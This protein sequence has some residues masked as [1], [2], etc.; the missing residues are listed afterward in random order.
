MCGRFTLTYDD[1]NAIAEGL[2]VARE[3]LTMFRPRY[4][5]AP[6]DTHLVVRMHGEE[7]E[8]LEAKWGLVNAWAKGPKQAFKNINAR[9][10]T[11]DSSPAFRKAFEKRRC[12]VP[13]DGFFEWEGPRNRR[14][15]HWYH[16]PDGGLILF[17][18]LYEWRKV[19]DAW[20]ATFAIVTTGANRLIAPVHDRMP[21]ILEDEAVDEW[22]LPNHPRPAELKRLLSPAPEALLVSRRVSIR[23]NDVRNDD[24]SVLEEVTQAGLV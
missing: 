7:R 5:I 21:V 1:V 23:V 9:A 14:Q 11:V 10:E 19:E 3:S 4:N 2:G 12:V 8:A 13:A 15:P 18:G 20:Q 24:P 16:R 6:T 17:A 22:M